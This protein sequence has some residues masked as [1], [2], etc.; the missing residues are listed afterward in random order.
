MAIVA[1]NEEP[2]VRIVRFIF[3]DPLTAQE[4]G[5]GSCPSNTRATLSG[6]TRRSRRSDNHVL[7]VAPSRCDVSASST[8]LRTAPVGARRRENR[9]R[10]RIGTGASR[11]IEP[12][13]LFLSAAPHCSRSPR[14]PPDARAPR[15][16]RYR[17]RATPIDRVFPSR[18][19]ARYRRACCASDWTS[20]LTRPMT[21]SRRRGT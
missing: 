13:P 2:H 9:S 4:A 19:H 14:R 15:V 3:A 17:Y 20:A 21:R 7:I 16:S 11:V 18:H 10:Y 1:R 8:P 6:A 5:I 12:L